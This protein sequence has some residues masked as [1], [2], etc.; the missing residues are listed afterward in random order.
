MMDENLFETLQ[1]DEHIDPGQDLVN[2]PLETYDEQTIDW[3]DCD[4]IC[5]LFDDIDNNDLEDDDS[6]VVLIK[7]QLSTRSVLIV[8][9]CYTSLPGHY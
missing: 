8:E 1:H 7:P 6:A 5:D 4:T 3:Q 9:T 2:I